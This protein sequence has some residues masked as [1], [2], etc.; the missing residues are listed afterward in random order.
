MNADMFGTI[1]LPIS[2][3]VC[4]ELLTTACEGGS[5]YWLRGQVQYGG[6][7][8]ADLSTYGVLNVTKCFD[9]E[10][11][12]NKFADINYDTIRKGIVALLKPEANVGAH[13]K[14]SIAMMLIDPDNADYDAD[15]ADA[16]LQ[17]GMFGELVYG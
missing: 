4:R 7:P 16:V 14:K 11:R 8:D 5:V 1:T 13:H 2:D 12:S 3:A 9:V 10:D 6:D 17:F 15:D